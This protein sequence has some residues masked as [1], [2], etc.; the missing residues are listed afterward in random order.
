MHCLE[1][2]GRG[3]V[4]LAVA[5]EYDL[6]PERDTQTLHRVVGSPV[7]DVPVRRRSFA[8]MRAGAERRPAV[9]ALLSALAR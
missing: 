7:C 9:A 8:A 1:V 3:T 5:H 2:V 6:F 4:D